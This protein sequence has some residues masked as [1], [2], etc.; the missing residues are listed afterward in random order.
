M[1]Q[2]RLMSKSV[3]QGTCVLRASV[4]P[5]F[6]RQELTNRAED[7]PSACHVQRA[8]T[9]MVH[10]PLRSSRAR[11]VVIAKATQRILVS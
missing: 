4:H 7:S 11:E 6:V 8:N 1:A 2:M 3:Q 9:V 5:F 10:Q